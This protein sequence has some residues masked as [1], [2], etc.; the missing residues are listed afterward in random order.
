[1]S[2]FESLLTQLATVLVGGTGV[3]YAFM[4]YVME[5]ADEW[6]VV[7]HPWQPHV[8]HLH[9]LVA[10]LLVFA[11]GMI[12]STHVA[13]SLRNGG[14]RGRATGIGLLVSFV[15]MVVSGALIQTAV[16]P[17]WRS[18]WIG[19]H[20]ASSALWMMAWIAHPVWTRW[21]RV[22]RRGDAVDRRSSLSDPVS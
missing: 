1:M 12:W 5:P 18:V 11:V 8:Q 6:S 7:N 3:V 17:V 16:E 13:P 14:P 20:L 9:I 15:P 21:L 4:R 19:L 2:R 10:P 22:Q